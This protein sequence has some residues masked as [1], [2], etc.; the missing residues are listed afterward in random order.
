MAW[1]RTIEP[2]RASGRLARTYAAAVVRAG[3][4]FAILRAMSL[5]P[6]TLDAS[7]GLYM[8]VAHGPSPLSRREREMLAVVVSRTNDCHY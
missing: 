4:V 5:T 8:S 2:E 6:R 7:M 3:K 1:L